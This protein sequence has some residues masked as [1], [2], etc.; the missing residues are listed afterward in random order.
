MKRPPEGPFA[1]SLEVELLD[2]LGEPVREGRARS[3][4]AIVRAALEQ[5]DFENLVVLKPSQVRIS[6]RL[7]TDVRRA[8]QAAARRHQVSVGHLVRAAVE[9]HLPRLEQSAAGQLEM[10]IA[11]EADSA[12]AA[13]SAAPAPRRRRA[14]SR[15]NPPRRTRR[16]QGGMTKKR[17]G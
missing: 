12:S 3:V 14:R 5:F 6:F 9:R 8:L 11:A 10:P 4:S 7:P 1:V 15:R 13:P 16:R 2:R 17:K